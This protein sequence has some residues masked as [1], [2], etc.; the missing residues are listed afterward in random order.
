M[1]IR[2]QELRLRLQSLRRLTGIY[3]LKLGAALGLDP[4]DIGLVATSSSLAALS[5]DLL[6]EAASGTAQPHTTAA[7]DG[8]ERRQIVSGQGYNFLGRVLRVSLPIQALM[9]LLLGVA[10]L[11]PS[12]EEDYSCILSNNLARSFPLIGYH[13]DGPPPL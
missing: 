7:T 5:R 6:D 3:S 12:T 11:I 10:S 8:D 13:R 1:R 4:R 9:L 2:L